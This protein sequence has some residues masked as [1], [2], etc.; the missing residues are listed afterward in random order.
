MVGKPRRLLVTLRSA[1]D[2]DQAIRDAKKLRNSSDA[3]TSSSV[4]VNRD[5][6]PEEAKA[7]Y[8]KRVRRRAQA[9]TGV[10]IDGVQASGN[11]TTAAAASTSQA[12]T[13]QN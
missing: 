8:E 12:A 9:T 7:A 2:V 10:S 13:H 5:L 11:A 3:Y 4:Y 6:S 1:E